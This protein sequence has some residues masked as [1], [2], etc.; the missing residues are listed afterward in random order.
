MADKHATILKSHVFDL[1]HTSV[2]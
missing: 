1:N 2:S